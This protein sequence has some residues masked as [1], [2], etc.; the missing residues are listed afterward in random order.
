MQGKL[1]AF[2]VVASTLPVGILASQLDSL[3]IDRIYVLSRELELSYLWFKAKHPKSDIVRVPS[4]LFLQSIYFLVVL[5]RARISG[6]KVVFFHECCMPIF[7]LIVKMVKPSGYY[8]PQVTMAGFEEIG[9]D[10]FPNSA[11]RRLL[12][13]LR[14][15]DLYK[16]YRSPAVA[17]HAREYVVSI[18]S[19][20]ETIICKDVIFSRATVAAYFALDHSGLKKV[21]FIT[22]K[23]FVADAIQSD[24]FATLI[25]EAI[26]LGYDCHVKDH[27]NPVYRLNLK[28]AGATVIDP[29][30]PVELLD[31]DYRL[32]VGVSSSA[33]LA[34]NE[35]AVSL[36]MLLAGMSESDK[37]LCIGHFENA[38]PGNR[39]R[40]I[41]SVDEFGDL[42][43]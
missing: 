2:C 30:M 29:L 20:P 43:R 41:N 19:Y 13:A 11:M 42:L 8:F 1:R 9:V 38:L 12:A 5:L 40:Y 7:D 6:T 24:L 21:L 27:P 10:E 35:R 14:V 26:A 34:F 36:V 33:L 37:G 25:N 22:G 28:A 39:I 15:V 31:R 3:K 16:F 17:D 18:R 32:A 23:T 4:G